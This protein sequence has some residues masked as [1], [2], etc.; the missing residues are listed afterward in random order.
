MP[1]K[2]AGD[3]IV[4]GQTRVINNLPHNGGTPVDF[5]G[6]DSVDV[7]TTPQN[8]GNSGVVSTPLAESGVREP[9]LTY[10][11]FPADLL[12]EPV[13]GYVKASAAAIGCDHAFVAMPLLAAVASAIGSKRRIRLKKRWTEPAILW[14]LTIATSGS[15]KSPGFDAA[16]L[17][18]RKRQEKARRRHAEAL[19]RHA[20]AMDEY[21]AEH[22]KWKAAGSQD[23]EPQEPDQPVLERCWTDNTTMEALASLLAQNPRGLLLA[24]DELSA[25][26]G[27]FDRYSKNKAN[28]DAAR[29]MHVHGGR[30]FVIDRKTGIPPVIFVEHGTVSVAGSIQPGVLRR[31]LTTEHQESGLASRFLFAMPPKKQKRWT[32]A[33]IDENLEADVLVLFDQLYDFQPDRDDD[34]EPIARIVKLSTAAKHDVW[35]PFYN[36]HAKEQIELDDD[37]SAAWSKLEGY[38]AR[39]ALVHHLV[40]VA[41]GDETVIDPDTVDEI[42]MAA[43]IALSQWF[44]AEAKRVYEMLGEAEKDQAERQLIELIDRLGGIV[45]GRDLQRR[46]RKFKTAKEAEN[47]LQ[48][49]VQHERGEWRTRPGTAQG[50]RPTSEFFLWGADTTPMKHRENMGCVSVSAQEND[51]WGEI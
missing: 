43:G 30:S 7:D 18:V 13:R 6:A 10:R 42:S 20:F 51:E 29:W 38:A 33:E 22:K 39:L 11:P 35:I 25:W 3:G 17:P 47:A 37:L 2:A 19:K 41:A 4:N 23:N 28:A 15:H 44:G 8:A 46:S 40:R 34:G 16:M 1:S 26:F 32:E 48:I 9:L 36:A 14:S 50:G 12:P 31:T 49:L 5:E 21:E 27:S 24:C 45:T